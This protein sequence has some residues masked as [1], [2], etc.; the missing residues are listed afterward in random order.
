MKL[1]NFIKRN[2]ILVSIVLVLF[3]VITNPSNKNFEDY[4]PSKLSTLKSDKNYDF[5]RTGMRAKENN[6]FVF[7]IFQVEF[8]CTNTLYTT[9]SPR[10]KFR[11][12]G[13]AKN[14]ILINEIK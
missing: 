4:L 9:A 8:T 11:Y 6:F 13:I 5:C 10:Y 12:L 1:I 7:S 14:F 3:F 2:K